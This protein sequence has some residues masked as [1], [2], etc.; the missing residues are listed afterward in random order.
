MPHSDVSTSECN[1]DIAKFKP[2]SVDTNT[3]I[4]TIIV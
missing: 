1:R 2:K 4:L 3:V